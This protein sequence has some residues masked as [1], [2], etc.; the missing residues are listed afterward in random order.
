MGATG[1]CRP[2]DCRGRLRHHPA[3]HPNSAGIP[4]LAV[5]A[6]AL[7]AFRTPAEAA[8]PQ[9]PAAV[10]APGGVSDVA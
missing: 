5:D 6:R 3:R 8:R 4:S 2:G 9:A 7:S 1:L 10:W